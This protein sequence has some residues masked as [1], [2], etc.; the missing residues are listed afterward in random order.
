[1]SDGQEVASY[2]E[3]C[4]E[5]SKACMPFFTFYRPEIR[6][7]INTNPKVNQNDKSMGDV[8]RK[9]ILIITAKF[10]QLH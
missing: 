1:M 7:A 4:K 10:C 8:W 6:T 2:R 9:Y 3:I 5:I